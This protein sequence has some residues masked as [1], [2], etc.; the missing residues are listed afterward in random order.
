M[1]KTVIVRYKTT[2]DRADENEGLVRQISGEL[3]ATAP[4]GVRYTALRL[5]DG[6]S[7]IATIEALDGSN[8]ILT[9][10]HS[11]DSRKSWHS[12]AKNRQRDRAPPRLA[13]IPPPPL[14]TRANGQV[15]ARQLI[16]EPAWSRDM[17]TGSIRASLTL[18]ARRFG[19]LR[20]RRWRAAASVA[21]WTDAARRLAARR[22][23]VAGSRQGDG[24]PEGQGRVDRGRYAQ[25]VRARLTSRRRELFT[26]RTGLAGRFPRTS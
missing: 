8:P 12:D 11:P 18:V 4:D 5:D 6:V 23:P 22:T 3:T 15:L 10:P 9:L 20:R 2:A 21:C 13:R 7:F 19:S 25:R 1:S 16:A 26:R 17:L 14:T 24:G